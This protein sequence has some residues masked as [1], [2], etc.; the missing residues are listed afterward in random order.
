MMKR[1][2]RGQL[3]IFI[4]LAILIIA[5]V[6]FIFLFYPKIKGETGETENPYTFI[7]ECLEDSLE[8]KIEIISSQGGDY[9]VNPGVSFFYRGDYIRFLCYT[10][11]Y[12]KLC[13][14]QVIF[15]KEHFESEISTNIQPE[16][17]ACFDSLVN[18]YENKGY[19]VSI[20]EGNI[21]V[22]ILP[23]LIETRFNRELTMKKGSETQEYKNFYL[24]ENSNLFNL[25]EVADNIIIWE[26][27]LGGSPTELYSLIEEYNVKASGRQKG[28]DDTLYVLT[29][30]DTGE[31]FRFAS[32]SYAA[33]AGVN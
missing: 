3:T 18:S 25:L 19:D 15:L 1:G 14:R 24:R 22:E 11:E 9:E 26:E 27:T 33:P 31:E 21:E 13:H 8:E 20:T 5:I 7:E 6:I 4:I 17:E 28:D 29:D 23:G 30:I 12:N 2:K 16:V 10:S 32:R